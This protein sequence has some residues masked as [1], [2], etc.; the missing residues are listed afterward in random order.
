MSST[1]EIRHT[2]QIIMIIPSSQKKN[3]QGSRFCNGNGLGRGR[4]CTNAG[5]QGC[6]GNQGGTACGHPLGQL[7]QGYPDVVFT[8]LNVVPSSTI[9]DEPAYWDTA[10]GS[11]IDPGQLG[12]KPPCTCLCFEGWSGPTCSQRTAFVYLENALRDLQ[13]KV[14]AVTSIVLIVF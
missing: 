6:I 5:A 4:G 14:D 9:C 11:L 7:A 1:P 13:M 10:A 3:T 12:S 8:R 2:S